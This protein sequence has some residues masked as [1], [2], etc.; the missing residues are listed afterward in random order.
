MVGSGITQDVGTRRHAF[1][2]LLGKT[3]ASDSSGTPSACSPLQV[4][5][6]V[7]HRC[8]ASI[9][10]W[11]SAADCT[12]SSSPVNH[13]RPPAGSSNDRNSYRPVTAG[14]RVSRMC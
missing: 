6:N 8:E 7:I 2:E 14:V 11:A 3:V 10:A 4:N 5:A 12:R 1:A 13:A 9:V